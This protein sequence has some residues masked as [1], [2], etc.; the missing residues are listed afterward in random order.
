MAVRLVNLL[1]LGTALLPL[2]TAVA[3]ADDGPPPTLAAAGRLRP[4]ETVERLASAVRLQVLV[5][6]RGYAAPA[7]ERN[8]WQP[9]YDATPD[10]RHLDFGTDL[11]SYDTRGPLAVSGEALRRSIQRLVREE[12]VDNVAIVSVSQGGLVTDEAFRA[13]LSSRDNVTTWTTL[14]SPLNGSSTAR[15]VRDADRVASAL[16]A[17][18]ELAALVE[19]LG[20][21]L[22][23]PALAALARERRFVAPPGVRFT[24]FW[25]LT[26]PLVSAADANVSGAT[27]RTL[28]PV[29]VDAHGGQI[30]DPRTRPLVVDAIRGRRADPPWWESAVA[31]LLAPASD[32]L[33]ASI[34]ATLAVAFVTTAVVIRWLALPLA[35]RWP[36]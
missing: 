15:L 33:R 32:V 14:G 3:Y 26:D 30:R 7:S 28:T 9:I 10:M 1:V 17:H 34:Y 29:V 2:P 25:A 4:P 13:G 36:A 6:V 11:G 20:A 22:D 31:S 12:D 8:R 35:R 18:R 16:G 27:V 21:G 23:D 5:S 19:P 24:Q